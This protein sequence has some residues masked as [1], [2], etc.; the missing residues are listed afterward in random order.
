MGDEIVYLYT[1]HKNKLRIFESYFEKAP[2]IY[3]HGEEKLVYIR[4]KDGSRYIVP[5]KE[6]F[7]HANQL[8]LSERDDQKA[9]HCLIDYKQDKIV[10]LEIDIIKLSEEIKNLYL[11]GGAKHEISD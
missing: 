4:K 9:I 3:P 6:G 2:V 7:V 5:K 11:S 10:K 8:W 1:F